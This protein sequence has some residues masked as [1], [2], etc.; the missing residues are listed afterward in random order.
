MREVVSRVVPGAHISRETA[1]A[2]IAAALNAAHD[3]K[4]EASIAVVD[5]GGALRCFARTNGASA[6]TAD[7]AIGKAWTSATSGFPTHV[8]NQIVMDPKLTPLTQL[9]RMLAISGGHPIVE[10]GKVVGAIGV[11]GGMRDQDLRVAVTAL[12]LAGFPASLEL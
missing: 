12:Q 11:S 7:V 1:D 2:L 4:F 9:P 6:M 5:A 10:D 3:A 8:W